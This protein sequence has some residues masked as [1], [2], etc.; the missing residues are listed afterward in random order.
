MESIKI[1][2]SPGELIGKFAILRI[3]SE[4]TDD[5]AKL[6]NVRIELELLNPWR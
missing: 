3:K 1:D 2:V 5:P 6:E 4:R